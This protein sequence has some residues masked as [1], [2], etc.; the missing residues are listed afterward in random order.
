MHTGPP[1]SVP[2]VL[3]PSFVL[4]EAASRGDAP[5]LVD[6]PTGRTLTYSAL[7]DSVDRVAAGLAAR[8][9]APGDV[10]GILS[11]NLPEFP[12]AFHGALRAGGTATTMNP[13]SSASE[14]AHQ[15]ADSRAR[16][17]LTVPP[18]LATAR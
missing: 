7:A 5:A 3:L 12:V 6:G 11:P 4:R 9:F 15:L 14:L 10:F 16:F 18:L 8:G 17:L 2:D 1:I 13:L